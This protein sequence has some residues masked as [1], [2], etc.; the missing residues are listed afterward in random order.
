MHSCARLRWPSYIE[1]IL[2]YVDAYQTSPSDL[3][4]LMNASAYL[5]SVGRELGEILRRPDLP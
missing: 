3:A 5:A 2:E 4:W 1:A